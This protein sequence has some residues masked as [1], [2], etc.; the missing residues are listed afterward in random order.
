MEI[1]G[2]YNFFR[3]SIPF[4]AAFVGALIVARQLLYS[5][6]ENRIGNDNVY[7]KIDQKFSSGLIKDRDD[8]Q[9]IINSVSR[10]ENDVYS[11]APVL[12]DYYTH[13]LSKDSDIEED[14]LERRYKIIKEILKEENKEKPFSGVP[15]EER[16]ILISIKDALKNN[17]IN[18]IDFNVDELNS[19][20]T[21]RNKLLER[22]TKLNRW[23]V[24]LAILGVFF[25][26]LFGILS[27]SPN[28]IDYEKINSQ[29]EVLLDNAIESIMG[30]SNYDSDSS[31][32]KSE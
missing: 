32:N 4:I 18:A 16:R 17:D 13:R 11:I 20:L 27:L 24:P 15:D 14:E 2:L 29:N 10:V 6:R 21:T 5:K 12:E 1:E 28:K 8:I 22:S 23:S 26:I 25:T 19:V 30:P 9:L 7:D 31:F 3:N